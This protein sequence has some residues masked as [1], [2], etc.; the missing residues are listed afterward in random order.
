MTSSMPGGVAELLGLAHHNTVS[1]YQHRYEDMPRP[2]L[3]LGKASEALAEA[4]DRAVGSRT[5]RARSQ[6]AES[7]RPVTTTQTSIRSTLW[8]YQSWLLSI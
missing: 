7:L 8:R 6:T 1:V 2:V 4:R 3:D 5:V